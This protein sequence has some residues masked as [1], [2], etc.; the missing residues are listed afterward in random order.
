MKEYNHARIEKKWQ[1]EWQKKG[2]YTVKDSEKGKK[3]NFVLV[4]FPYPSGNLHVG[5]WYAFAVPDMYARTMRMTGKNV[6]FPI[7]FDAF[8]LPAENAAIKRGIN[9]RT[10]TYKNMAH[11]RK[12]IASMGTSFD[13]TREVVTCDPAY[14]KWTQWLFLQLYKKGLVHRKDTSANWCPSCKTVLANEQVIGGE[15]ER[16]GHKVEQRLM[17]QWNIA[18]T[19][20]ADR[21]VDDL[22]N[23]DWPEA[24]KDSQRNWIGRSE[25]AE[26]DFAL[27][28]VDSCKRVVILHGRNGSPQSHAFPWLKRKLEERGYTV[29]MPTLPHTQE[30]DL[31][32]QAAHVMK[33]CT[34][35]ESTALVGV[36]FGGLVALRVLELGRKVGRVTLISTPHSG[37]FLDKK[38][39]RSVTRACKHQYDI[40]TIRAHAKSFVVLTDET[41]TIVPQSDASEWSN[42]LGGLLIKGTGVVPHF[43]SEKGEPDMLMA[44]TP[45]VRVFT[46]RPDTIF[47][48][49]YMVLAPEHPWVTGALAQ[50]GLIKNEKE[51][52]AYRTQANQKTELERQ[53]NKVKTGVKLLGV[54]AINP[55][56]K[57]EI[58]VFISDYVLAHYG[59]GAIMAVPGHDER[60]N[61]FAKSFSL[62]IKQVV[63]RVVRQTSG[64]DAVR[65]GLPF[66][67]RRAVMCIV[68]HWNKDEYLC[69]TW[70]NYPIRSFISGGIERDESAI[71]AGIREIREESGYKN[72]RF[73]R[74]IGDAATVEFFHTIKQENRRVEFTYLYFELENDE[75]GH[76]DA[77]ELAKHTHEWKPAHEVLPFLTIKEKDLLWKQHTSGQHQVHTDSGFLLDSGEYTG[78]HSDSAKKLIVESYGRTKKTYRLR[79]WIV[80][81]QRYWGV[82]IPMIHCSACGYVPVPEKS[83][84]V[85]LP[86]VNDYL[87]AGDGKSPLAK[88]SKWVKTTCPQCKAPASRETDTFD[89]FICS[90]WYYLRY[91]DP[92]NKKEFA[93]RKKLQQW[94][95]VDLYSGGAEHTTMHVLYSRFWHKALYDMKLVREKEPYAKRMNRGLILGPDGQKMSKSKGNVID[96]DDVVKKLGADTVRMYLAFIGPF[97]EP[98]SYPW[99][100]EAIVGVRRFLE[101]VWRLQEKI[102]LGVHEETERELHKVI[103]KITEDVAGLKFNTAIAALMS[104]INVAEKHGIS[105]S[106]FDSLVTLLAPFAPHISE[107]LWHM[108]GHKKS[109]HLERF[110]RWSEK[111][112]ISSSIT[113]AVQVNGKLR[114]TLQATPN[115]A[116]DTL[117]EMALTEVK[118]WIG[119][120]TP[121]RVIVIPNKIVN[122][123][124]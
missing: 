54:H 105:S 44:I 30:P 76:V 13:W 65:D 59:T 67:H 51:V 32:E 63:S 47:G 46:T 18:I 36:S 52:I 17:P 26:I 77:D 61:A 42:T 7:G 53:E 2:L 119:E 115:L 6:L 95:P 29:E 58:P 113:I 14:Y 1:K 11:M 108:R 68:K 90:S 71:E 122:I 31:D 34:L 101:R 21:L 106:Q 96:P 35:D 92:K 70:N 24:I 84:P 99:S 15:C 55:A 9:P 66:V 120:G 74:Q 110:P 50:R 123:V 100:P 72:P 56:T 107:E 5:H 16:C 60:D 37:V 117:K 25:G 22:D 114:G 91:A 103:K 48:A 40:A 41:D 98:G 4:E 109:V 86:R 20:Y 85:E 10:W 81:R 19:K 28:G 12:Q 79:D 82:P 3:N 93:Q 94:L 116:E 45:T 111:K 124:L 97:N 75:Q 73:I 88:A 102:S 39:R 62:P 87:P 112:L 8:G 33:H 38:A 27:S 80:S 121:R 23:L 57:E 69:Q 118:K 43:S 78:M 104:F 89:T 83:L 49:T 64:A